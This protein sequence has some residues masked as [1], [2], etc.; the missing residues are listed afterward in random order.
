MA[1]FSFMPHGMCYLWKPWLVG[2]HLVSNGAIALAYFSIP[3]TLIYILRKREDIPFNGIFWLFAAFILFCGTGHTIDIWTLWHPNYWLSSWI[4][5]LTA[6]VSCATALALTIK[7]PEILTLPSPTQVNNINQQL[8]AKIAELEQQKAIIRQQEEFLR[9]IYDSVQEAIFVIKVELD[10]TFCYQGFNPAAIEL[11]GISDVVGK[12]PAQ[13]MSPEAT[14]AVE[15]RYTECLQAATA[16]TYEECL[17]F[18]D[19][20]TWW[21]TNLNPIKDEAGHISRLIGTSLN[22]NARKQAE[23][24]LDRDKQFLQALLDNLS[25]GIVSCDRHG[26]ITLFNRATR[27]FH[28]LPESAIPA[29]EWAEYYNLYLPDGQTKM[30][31]EDIPLFRALTGEFVRD[32]EMKIIPKKGKPR[33]L[34]A[35]GNPIIDRQGENMGAIVAMRDITERKEAEA[36][37]DRER[38]FIKTLL[39]NLSDGIVACDRDGNLVLF[40]QAMIKLYGFPQPAILADKWAQHYNLYD[41]EGKHHLKQEDIPLSRAFSGESFTNVEL[42]VIPQQGKP[43]ILSTNGSPIIDGN[44][45]KL[46]AV[47]AV[48]DIT[49]RKK[50]EQEVARLNQELE[51]RVKQRT[52]QLEQR[53]QELDQ[54]AYVTSHDLK[55]PLRAIANLSQW[56]E[57]DLAD[58]MEQETK[59]NM[60]LLRG[61]VHRLENL[62]NA[63]LA[64]SRVGRLKSD[65]QEVSVGKMLTD[66]MDLLDLPEH[67][68]VEIQEEMPTFITDAVPLQQVFNNLITNAIKHSNSLAGKITISAIE[69]A[70]H[71]QFVVADNGKGID[72]KYHD[73]IFTMFQTLE[74]RDTK[75]NTGIGL[76]I[77]KKAVENQGGQITIDSKL[78]DGATFCFTWLKQSS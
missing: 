21:L 74:S 53:N 4:K 66:I 76:A 58:K 31:Q 5:L 59:Y 44:G 16:I 47:V 55:A 29:S 11:T 39:N 38:V 40:N 45:V 62:I 73:R 64:Y 43:R 61:R 2:L 27:E 42:M 57:E 15:R 72:P 51:A 13:V 41:V 34:L 8:K 30:S 14:A 19:R 56:I 37:L 35:N 69:R 12:T 50:A 18:Q 48:Q 10:G 54:F 77:V 22:I 46:G 65:L 75:E 36:E 60:N 23:I 71:Y 67:F 24:E 70:D 7:I 9:T 20:D 33:T 52:A 6:L 3:I 68:Q 28:G 1:I 25:D 78:G 32:V 26:V 49:E 17:P 63:L